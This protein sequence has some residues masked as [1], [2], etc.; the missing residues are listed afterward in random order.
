MSEHT[1]TAV[2]EPVEE[3]GYVV[4]FPASEGQEDT[5]GGREV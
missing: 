3:D 4:T 1:Y 2:F 5:A